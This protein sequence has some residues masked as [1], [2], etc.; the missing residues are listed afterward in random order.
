MTNERARATDE[1]RPV[2]PVSKWENAEAKGLALCANFV[3]EEKL[4][5]AKKLRERHAAYLASLPSD[6]ETAVRAA[7]LL[8]HPDAEEYPDGFEEALHLSSALEAM[9]REGDLDTQGRSRDAALFLASQMSTAMH[10]AARQLD[11]IS[12]IL[13]NVRPTERGAELGT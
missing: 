5:T 1:D 3:F 4:A 9:V 7:W 2:E 11:L 6:P 8:L 12:D 10:R 13:E